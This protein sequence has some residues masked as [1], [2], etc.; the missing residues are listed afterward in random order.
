MMLLSL[1]AAVAAHQTAAQPARPVIAQPNPAVLRGIERVQDDEDSPPQEA[2]PPRTAL[3]A[4]FRNP[5]GYMPYASISCEHI[6]SHSINVDHAAV[7]CGGGYLYIYPYYERIRHTGELFS[8]ELLFYGNMW[9]IVYDVGEGGRVVNT[10]R[11]CFGSSFN[12]NEMETDASCEALWEDRRR[13]FL[14][15]IRWAN[16]NE[17]TLTFK[18]VR[19]NPDHPFIIVDYGFR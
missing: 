6:S 2:L 10:R 1:I 15:A 18:A 12:L 14:H 4:S 11:A 19:P 13:D 9:N 5:R 8:G 16:E 17:K 7:R 3:S